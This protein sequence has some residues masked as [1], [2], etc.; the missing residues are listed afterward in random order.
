MTCL[1]T[2]VPRVSLFNVVRNKELV[3]YSGD[4]YFVLA[5]VVGSLGF[6]LVRNEKTFRYKLSADMCE[7][8]GQNLRH[9][10]E[11]YRKSERRDRQSAWK[12]NVKQFA[13][14]SFT[15]SKRTRELVHVASSLKTLNPR[16]ALDLIFQSSQVKCT[17]MK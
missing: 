9:F 4:E 14:G 6:D 15:L 8:V 17:P 7:D 10:Y 12:T 11:N 13:N 1:G 3:C 5:D 2:K 16:R